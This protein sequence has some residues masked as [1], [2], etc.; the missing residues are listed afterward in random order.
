MFRLRILGTIDLRKA[1]GSELSHVLTQPRRLA[2][3][4][5]LAVARPRGFHRRDT[6][7]AL[8]W[9]EQPLER[10]RASLSR[11]L[12][13][14]RHE[15]GPGVLISRGDEDIGVNP[16]LL[17]CDA[18]ALEEE[19]PSLYRGDILTGFFVPGARGFEEW[20]EQERLR[21]REQAAGAAALLA[22]DAVAAGNLARA[23]KWGRRSLELSP[24][25]ES[26]LQRLLLLLDRAGD[27]AGAHRAYREFAERIAVELEAKP[28]PETETIMAA[29]RARDLP[30]SDLTVHPS[31]RLPVSSSHRAPRRPRLW[32]LASVALLVASFVILIA[33]LRRSDASPD[34]VYLPAFAVDSADA[35]LAREAR[36]AADRM[37]VAL[38]ATGLVR[39][40]AGTADPAGAGTVVLGAVYREE[41]HVRFVARI[42]EARTGRIVWT[43]FSRSAD[44]LAR[45]VTGGVAALT[46]PR[47]A[48][49]FPNASSPP[50]IEAFLEWNRADQLQS[51]GAD[52]D[53]VPYLERAVA[54]DPEFCWAELQLAAAHLALFDS[55]MAD[56]MI[57]ALQS[58]RER[59]NLLQRHWLDWM[60]AMAAEDLSGG[61]D[62]IAAAARIAPERFL[63]LLA[64]SATWLNRPREAIDLLERLGPDSPYNG[65]TAA[66]WR[67]V[68]RSHHAVG[69][70]S[71]EL[72]AARRARATPVPPIVALSF[73][74]IALAALGR[75]EPLRAKLDTAL[76]LPLDRGTSPRQLMAESGT[77][78]GQLM[79][80][81]AEELR[82][83][84]HE[85]AAEEALERAESWYAAQPPDARVDRARR[86]DLGMAAYYARDWLRADS[87]FRVLVAED[88]G[89]FV[90]LGRLGTVAA[91]LGDDSTARRILEQFDGFRSTLA[92]PHTS[93]GYWQSKITVL[94][95][96]ERRAL[97]LMSEAIGPQGRG[98][99]HADFDF[100]RIWATRLFRDFVR[101]K[102]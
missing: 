17:W 61:Y 53:A 1:D 65:G 59:L 69:D 78:A 82:A 85:A 99:M 100:E 43:V 50:L 87:L 31:H 97:A 73:E 47:F 79:V 89:N 40:I 5:Y 14:L 13:F 12:Y 95:G 49:W 102:G 9:S 58:R 8:F 30:G 41:G 80:L 24:F 22:E 20:L 39:V 46:M 63:Y 54:L 4:V 75:L 42:R 68:T 10:A 3:L 90:Y 28:S 36:L 84:G 81:V 29:I 56:P 72:S 11:A 70:F 77:S 57:E 74:S 32:I 88:P 62:A 92:T 86:F 15:L 2:L 38:A 96:D 93:V 98:G 23:E 7:L 6:L 64:M 55:R 66:Y 21:V 25:S 60:R 52:R 83:H 94:L 76:M 45:R 91:R 48:S 26:A 34:Q 101:P 44:T 33:G 71:G 18:V 35:A 19:G 37:A 51:R 67:L 27:R 16:D